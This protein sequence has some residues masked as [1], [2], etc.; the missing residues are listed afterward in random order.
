MV[1]SINSGI[2]TTLLPTAFNDPSVDKAQADAVKAG[3]QSRLDQ[4]PPA[5]QQ[6]FLQMTANLAPGDVDTPD[7]LNATLDAYAAAAKLLSTPGPVTSFVGDLSKF[8]A[9]A[10][11]EMASEQKQNALN[12]RL[13]AREQARADLLGQAKSMQDAAD[14]MAAGAMTSLIT[15][16]VGGALS[17]AGSMTSAISGLSQLKNMTQAVK[18]GNQVSGELSE[19]SDMIGKLN[20]LAPSIKNEQF[21]ASVEIKLTELGS[22]E[23]ALTQKLTAGQKAFDLASNKSQTYG[24][25]GQAASA[26]GDITRGIGSS[27][28]ATAQADAKRMDAEG[29]KD[30]A[31]AQYDQQVADSKKQVEDSLDDMIKQI[32]DFLK[33]M[34]DAEADAMRSLTRV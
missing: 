19:T 17:I 31:Q 23:N 33:Q 1:D 24:A 7:K 18:A 32:I 20:K 22:K 13:A 34:K 15:S 28:D 3:I 29:S 27:Q 4:M 16:V 8:L 21:A 25:L 9:R 5:E 2:N 14:K 12:D 30:A 10:M 11:I 6:A 26:G